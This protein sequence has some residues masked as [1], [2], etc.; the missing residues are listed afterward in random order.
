MSKT[1]LVA[2]FLNY[3]LLLLLL[4]SVVGFLS[5]ANIYGVFLAL[6]TATIAWFVCKHNRW[7]YFAAAAWGLAC[8]QLAKQ[9]YEFQAIKRQV[10]IVG[11]FVIPVA[12]FLH[13]VLAKVPTKSAQDEKHDDPSGSNMPD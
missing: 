12:L 5:F 9:G 10:M 3:V 2:H 1:R 8:Y 4:A 7:G 6:V 11:I 13:E